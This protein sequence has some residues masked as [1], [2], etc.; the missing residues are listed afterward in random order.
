MLFVDF[1][2]QPRTTHFNK[3]LNKAQN[4]F[5]HGLAKNPAGTPMGAA[6]RRRYVN[7]CKMAKIKSIP[8]SECTLIL[9][10]THLAS[11]SIPQ[12]TIKVYISA[13]RYMHIRKGPHDHVKCQ[14]TPLLQLILRKIRNVKQAHAAK[15]LGCQ[16][17]FRCFKA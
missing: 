11:H 12:G 10:A 5:H 13:I 1:L 9:F 7:F 6:W 3:L 17:L 14:M 16:S 8:T 15:E 2:N 4:L